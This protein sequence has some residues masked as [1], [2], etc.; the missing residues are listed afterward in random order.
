MLIIKIIFGAD[1][2]RYPLLLLNPSLPSV[3]PSLRGNRYY[4]GRRL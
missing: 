3:A 2:S 1:I 4:R